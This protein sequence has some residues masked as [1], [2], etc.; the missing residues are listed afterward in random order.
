MRPTEG[1]CDLNLGH[2]TAADFRRGIAAHQ[3]SR[4]IMLARHAT[5]VRSACWSGAR[6]YHRIRDPDNESGIGSGVGL[7]RDELCRQPVPGKDLRR[8]ID[9]GPSV[10]AFQ[11]KEHPS[12]TSKR[13]APPDEP[14]EGRDGSGDH[15]VVTSPVVLRA[16]AD[17][18]DPSRLAGARSVPPPGR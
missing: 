8:L 14:V 5:G 12:W 10:L 18:F 4:F 1:R 11:R 17:H 6:P 3:L 2:R 13:I 7:C 16:S 15:D 9:L